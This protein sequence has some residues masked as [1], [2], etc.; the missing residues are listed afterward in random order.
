M[1][2]TNR[3]RP[4]WMPS[5]EE[6][7]GALRDA[8]SIGTSAFGGGWARLFRN[9]DPIRRLIER[10]VLNGQIEMLT[11]HVGPASLRY[12]WVGADRWSCN[13]CR[14]KSSGPSGKVIA[15]AESCRWERSVREIA[16][17]RARLAE[18]EKG[19]P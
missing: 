7:L 13:D 4:S 14:A 17:L 18:L 6:I 19:E 8:V 16:S 2:D 15:H 5:D 10:A 9:S 3:E 12:E 1:S 11:K